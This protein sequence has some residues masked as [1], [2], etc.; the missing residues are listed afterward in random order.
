M[1]ATKKNS[2]TYWKV[3]ICRV[4]VGGVRGYLAKSRAVLGRAKSD[5]KRSLRGETVLPKAKIG[6]L[7]KIATESVLS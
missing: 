1:I 4:N 7:S 2:L 6:C 3:V 5:L